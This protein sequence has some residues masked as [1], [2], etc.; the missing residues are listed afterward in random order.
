LEYLKI[1]TMHAVTI[2]RVS[3]EDQ[4]IQNNSLPAQEKRML[5][6]CTRKGFE[7]VKKFSFDESAY[8]TNR[9]EFDTI[10]E[11][12]KSYKSF[13][14][15][16]FDKIDRLSRNVFDKRVSWLYEM[17]ISDKLELHFVSDNQVINSK[18]SAVEKFTFSMSLG[19]AKYYSDAISDNVR[20]ANEKLRGQGIK[21][22]F[23][24]GYIRNNGEVINTDSSQLIS[25]AFELF[26]TG[27]Y[28]QTEIVKYL[29]DKGYK[30]NAG[31]PLR[32]QAFFSMVRNPFYYGVAKSKYGNYNHIY[33]P[34]TTKTI[35]DKCQALLDKNTKLSRKQKRVGKPYP[36]RNLL[37]CSKCNRTINPY[38]AKHKY[39]YYRCF[40][41]DCIF[42]Q[43]IVKEEVILGQ[44][45]DLIKGI[46]FPKE[47]VKFIVDKLKSEFNHESLYQKKQRNVISKEIE[48]Y[49]ER[50]NRLT[51]LLV[52]GSITRDIYTKK[53]QEYESKLHELSLQLSPETKQTTD[54]HLTV[55]SMFSLINRLPEIFKSSNNEEKNKI[56]KY[57]ISNSLQT[58]NKADI[59][60]KKPFLFLYKKQDVLD[61]QTVADTLRTFD[62]SCFELTFG[63]TE[64]NFLKI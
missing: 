37:S 61:W 58:G 20:R 10:I 50:L 62:W 15:V 22:K 39:N 1:N 2:S 23:P 64:K 19:L 11:Y 16:C 63:Q 29:N 47:A 24:E 51:D 5:D 32:R 49:D 48:S 42:Y 44:A 7:V 40:N 33:K 25:E 56:L 9:D 45:E 55:E 41:K 31:K 17:A 4:R 13:L 21:F 34:L 8:K 57:L 36:F 60:L 35:F 28:S 59:Y 38:T 52:D 46:V 54:L 12:I 6:Y 43:D 27:S 30:N 18:I 26:S 53:Q 3:T 14:V